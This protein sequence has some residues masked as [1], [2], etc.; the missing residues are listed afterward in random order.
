MS[1]AEILRT[2]VLVRIVTLIGVAVFLILTNVLS[3]F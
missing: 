2:V 1:F 3:G